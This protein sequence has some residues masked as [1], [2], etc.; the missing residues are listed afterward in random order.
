MRT[1][2]R[3]IVAFVLS[4]LTLLAPACSAQSGGQPEYK[5]EEMQVARNA[6]YV[7]ASSGMRFPPRAGAF[8]RVNVVKYLSDASD[9]SAGYNLGKPRVIM[10]VYVAPAMGRTARAYYDES[11]AAIREKHAG[12]T[13]TSNEAWTLDQGD[14]KLKGHRATFTFDDTTGNGE[15]MHLR[16]ELYVFEV[17]GQLLKYRVTYQAADADAAQKRITEFM[18]ALAVP[19]AAE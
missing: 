1:A 3:F 5:A 2:V 9:V 10:T 12:V 7:H 8:A 11:R 16:S 4:G 15:M 13:E 14:Q 19:A 17:R 6:D 18:A